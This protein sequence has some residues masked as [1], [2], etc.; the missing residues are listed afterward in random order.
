MAGKGETLPDKCLHTCGKIVSNWLKK[1]PLPISSKFTRDTLFLPLV[2]RTENESVCEHQGV[3]CGG[4]EVRFS[5]VQHHQEQVRL[6]VPHDCVALDDHVFRPSQAQ[7][8]YRECL[9]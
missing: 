3:P 2:W 7:G 4:L 1:L 6:P 9:R 5:R 8:Q